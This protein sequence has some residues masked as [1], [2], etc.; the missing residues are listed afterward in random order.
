MEALRSVTLAQIKLN[1][2]TVEMDWFAY[3]IA[4]TKVDHDS[5]L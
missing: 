2:I 5:C 3:H 1:I 4:D